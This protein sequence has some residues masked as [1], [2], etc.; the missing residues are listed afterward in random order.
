MR[1]IWVNILR[2]WQ[3]ET[4]KID[5]YHE[6]VLASALPDCFCRSSRLRWKLV[7]STALADRRSTPGSFD[8]YD[9]VRKEWTTLV[10]DQERKNWWIDTR[11][12]RDPTVIRR[13]KLELPPL[14]GEYPYFGASIS[15]LKMSCDA[16]ICHEYVKVGNSSS[17]VQIEFRYCLLDPSTG[18]LLRRFTIPN[19]P[20][21]SIAGHGSKLAFVENGTIKLFDVGTKIERSIKVA[22][23]INLTFSSDGK[24]LACVSRITNTLYFINWEK[25]VLIEPVGTPVKAESFCFVTNDTILLAHDRGLR[26]VL[27]VHSRWHWDGSALKQVSPGIKLPNNQV[28]PFVKVTLGGELHVSTQTLKDWHL[29]LKPLLQWLADKKV[30]IE[31]W[32]HKQVFRHWVVLDEHDQIKREY[33]EGGNRRKRRELFDQ[34]SVEV[35]SEPGYTSSTITLWNEHPVWPNALA[36]GMML[37]LFLYVVMLVWQDWRGR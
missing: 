23:P 20:I 8:Q 12:G 31:S 34:L 33:Y 7:G 16:V 18:E 10:G 5:R 11:A 6:M 35:A 32:Y 2:Q 3:R 27:E 4:C 17:R 28:F 13:L 22:N 37:Y 15:V 1:P 9:A 14:T 26:D 25:A 24:L 29:Q 19:N 36:A 21:D 30:A